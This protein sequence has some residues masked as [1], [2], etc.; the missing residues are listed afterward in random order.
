[1][2]DRVIA[3]RVADAMIPGQGDRWPAASLAI[4]LADLVET[5]RQTL[6]LDP[7][8]WSLRDTDIPAALD[9]LT[10]ADPAALARLRDAIYSAYY[11]AP[12]VQAAIRA[13]AEAAPRDPQT[14]FDARLLALVKRRG[15]HPGGLR[16]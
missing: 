8:A 1:M 5:I 13:I 11:A 2:N 10:K 6:A 4:D 15:H 3:A 9:A 7:D 16:E 12:A 14:H